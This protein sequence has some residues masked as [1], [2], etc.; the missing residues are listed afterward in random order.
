MNKLVRGVAAVVGLGVGLAVL[1]M[2]PAGNRHGAAMAEP[3]SPTSDLTIHGNLHDAKPTDRQ[4]VETRVVNASPKACWDKWATS[5]GVG[6]FLTK[7]STVEL[8]IGGPF[9][10]YFAMQLPEG[11]R[12]SEGCKILSYLPERMLSFEWNA[13]PT[14]PEVREKRSRVVV[15]FDEVE[16][17]TRV[18][19][20]HLGFGS[21]TQWDQVHEYFTQAWPRVMDSFAASFQG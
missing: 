19:L 9:E 14:F 17:G 5:E 6:S 7:N 20:T 12:G 21:G 3:D 11:H 18:E 15:M 13:P 10:V 8:R 1:A 16:N 2:G 4:I